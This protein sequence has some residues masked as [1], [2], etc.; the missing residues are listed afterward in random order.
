MA[1]AS[2]AGNAGNAAKA[3]ALLFSFSDTRLLFIGLKETAGY[4]VV[5]FALKTFVYESNQSPCLS[6]L[7]PNH[8]FRYVIPYL[9]FCYS[10]GE[11]KRIMFQSFSTSNSMFANGFKECHDLEQYFWTQDTVSRL[12]H[13]LEFSMDCCCLVTPSLAQA[14]HNEGRDEV[15]LDI[16]DRFAYLPRYIKWDLQSPEPV[17]A[18]GG[19]RFQIIVFD[20][21]FFYIPIQQLFGAVMEVCASDASTKIMIGFLRREEPL[22]L[23]TF[24]VFQ[25]RR[26]SFKLEY[27][28]VKPN[29]WTNYALYT[30]VDLPGIKRLKANTR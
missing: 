4:I 9:Y 7:R 10:F 18:G 14:W 27:A 17:D 23:T 13:A 6:H 11:T 3:T 30:N 19:R 25:L 28:T 21:P 24:K 22:L 29:K 20:P 8:S 12:T 26:T 16:D 5:G 15:L 2:L 1:S